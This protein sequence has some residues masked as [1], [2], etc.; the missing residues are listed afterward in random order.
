M[1][2]SVSEL[3]ELRKDLGEPTIEEIGSTVRT[4][5]R[6]GRQCQCGFAIAP[7]EKYTRRALKVDGDFH[8]E[9]VG[10]HIHKHELDFGDEELDS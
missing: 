9:I 6:P 10:H 2:V 8:V 5:A 4:A 3:R 1:R 7:G